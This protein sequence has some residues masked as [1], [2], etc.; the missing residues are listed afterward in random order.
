MSI[1][2]ISPG[3]PTETWYGY[4][5]APIRFPKKAEYT[6]VRTNLIHPR[7]FSS[8]KPNIITVKT[9]IKAC[10]NPPKSGIDS[11]NL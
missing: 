7:Y 1:E 8:I 11:N 5:N 4:T 9:L 6:I 10:S 3:V 2:N